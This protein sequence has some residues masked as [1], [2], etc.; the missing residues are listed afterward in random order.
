MSQSRAEGALQGAVV[1]EE[2]R[3]SLV[4]EVGVGVVEEEEVAAVVQ[5]PL[6]EQQMMVH[7]ALGEKG[8]LFK[9]S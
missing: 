8:P 1:G 4:L 6:Q 3:T 7:L 9:L 2:E 5:G